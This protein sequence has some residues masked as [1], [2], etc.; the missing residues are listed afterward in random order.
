MSGFVPCLCDKDRQLLR[1][2][3]AQQPV[4]VSYWVQALAEGYPSFLQGTV[5]AEAYE[6]EAM[7]TLVLWQWQAALAPCEGHYTKVL[8]VLRLLREIDELQVGNLFKLRCDR[9]PDQTERR[10]NGLAA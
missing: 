10:L 6:I 4:R 8:E 7:L 9:G 1:L 3:V 5:K 2:Y